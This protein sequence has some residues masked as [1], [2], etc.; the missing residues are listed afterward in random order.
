[1]SDEGF[2]IHT[3]I[4]EMILRE[5]TENTPE[6]MF[7]GACTDPSLDDYLPI[8]IIDGEHHDEV[9]KVCEGCPVLKECHAHFERMNE[10]SRPILMGIFG[11]VD[12][13]DDDTH[14]SGKR[15]R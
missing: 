10:Y 11:G 15:T 5:L 2:S 1:M 7:K 13:T 9:M 14:R 4:S 3:G 8:E 12:Y 6:F